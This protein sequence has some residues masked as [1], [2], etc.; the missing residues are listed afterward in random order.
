MLNPTPAYI[1]NFI[2]DQFPEFYREINGPIVD[3]VLAYYEWLEQEGQ[4][5][6]ELRGLRH[7]RDIDSNVDK[8]TENFKNM[9]MAGAPLDTRSDSRF[10]LKHISDL[11]QSKG[12]SRS[13]NYLL[14]CSMMKK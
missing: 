14:S 4:N 1:S 7:A 9:F 8:F 5:T 11:Y 12:S 10:I 2:R 3:F 6:K 13:I